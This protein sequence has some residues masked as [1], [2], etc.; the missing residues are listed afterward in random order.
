M[1]KEYE[2]QEVP[3]HMSRFLDGEFFYID[4][5][6]KIEETWG[7]KLGQRVGDHKIEPGGLL[8]IDSWVAGEPPSDDPGRYKTFADILL[9]KDHSKMTHAELC[10]LLSV[11]LE[12]VDRGVCVCARA[13]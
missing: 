8:K 10:A 11:I 9:F 13:L 5:G 3:E 12:W 2:Q 6:D 7:N 1:K 4:L